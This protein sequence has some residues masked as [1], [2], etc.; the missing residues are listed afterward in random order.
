MISLLV[1]EFLITN[2]LLSG[3]PLNIITNGVVQ[4]KHE[5]QQFIFNDG[6]DDYG[7]DWY[8]PKEKY[9]DTI[10]FDFFNDPNKKQISLEDISKEYEKIIKGKENI[11][12]D[13]KED[14]IEI[15]PI[16]NNYINPKLY[17]VENAINGQNG[18]QEDKPKFED[19]V[20]IMIKIKPKLYKSRPNIIFDI[21]HGIKIKKF[22]YILD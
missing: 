11:I 21:N 5:Q 17:L 4:F 3:D 9:I 6:G 16:I 20:K 14:V 19:C 13:V 7:D 18:I 15:N 2:G 22:E 8:G 10:G 1:P 12:V